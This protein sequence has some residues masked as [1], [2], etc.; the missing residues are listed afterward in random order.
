MLK[1]L[2][3]QKKNKERLDKFLTEQLN[4][5]S[6]SQI[7]KLIRDGLVKVNHQE[8]SVHH[9]LKNG[10]QI[11]IY[12]VP[13]SK[14]TKIKIEPKIIFENNDFF[15]INK[16][17]GLPVEGQKNEYC[18]IDWLKEKRLFK[19]K[20]DEFNRRAGLIHRLDKDVSG[21]MAIARN[22]IFFQKLKEQ[23]KKRTVKKVYLGLVYGVLEKDEGKLDFIMARGE[24]GKMVA[25]PINQEGKS[26]ITEFQVLKRF[27]NYTYLQAKILT[28]RTHQIRVHFFAFNHPVVGDKLYTQKKIK[29]PANLNRLFLHSHLLGF[30]DADNQWREFKIDLPKE[31]KDI[32]KKLK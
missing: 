7:Q 30:Y 22:P 27:K 6:R 31:L 5:L 12:L 21:V 19:T 17:V 10:D 4:Y 16:P 1:E 20:D 8:T 2:L 11:K 24:N 14:P 32:L 25:R 28:G 26:A 3:F 9:F 23:F 18:L 29:A 13:P 15:I